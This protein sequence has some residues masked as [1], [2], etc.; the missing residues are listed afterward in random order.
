MSWFKNLLP[1]TIR[2]EGGSKKAI[3]EGIWSKCPQCD[4]VLY[5]PEMERNIDVC[6]KCGNHMRIGARRRLESFLDEDGREEIG[7]DL[8]PVDVLRFKDKKNTGIAS[9]RLRKLREKRML[10]WSYVAS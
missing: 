4:V 2:T 7:A 6:P 5:R 3:P 10:W 1:A 8:E 9:T